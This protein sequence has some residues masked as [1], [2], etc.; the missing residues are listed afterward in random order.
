MGTTRTQRLG[1]YSKE[2][3][4]I[5]NAVDQG[6]PAAY[7]QDSHALAGLI[8][9][10]FFPAGHE[11]YNRDDNMNTGK[12]KEKGSKYSPSQGTWPP[13]ETRQISNV[14]WP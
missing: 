1:L 13:S 4:Q 5:D 9:N 6:I 10:A 7:R 8:L 12:E 3:Q 14:M 11:I 2:Y